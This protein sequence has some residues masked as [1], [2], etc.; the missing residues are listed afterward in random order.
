[1]KVDRRVHRILR[2]DLD[3]LTRYLLNKARE[4]Y[5]GRFSRTRIGIWRRLPPGTAPQIYR[6]DA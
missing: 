2:E 4:I 3:D 6:Q 5:V 1:M